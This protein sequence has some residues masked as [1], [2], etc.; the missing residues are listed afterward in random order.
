MD[1]SKTQTVISWFSP[2]TDVSQ[3][4]AHSGISKPTLRPQQEIL[5]RASGWYLEASDLQCSGHKQMSTK[6]SSLLADSEAYPSYP[7]RPPHTNPC[8][9][10]QRLAV[11]GWPGKRKK[12]PGAQCKDAQVSK[13]LATS[14][15]PPL[16]TS[17]SPTCS[18]RVTGMIRKCSLVCY[19]FVLH[20]RLSGLSRNRWDAVYL[21]FHTKPALVFCVVGEPSL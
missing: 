1:R 18:S 16:S 6:C 7:A 8:W 10:H 9:G 13:T 15:F 3:T 4:G 5:S 14:P 11:L 21:I 12:I 2:K 20:V 19:S 17:V